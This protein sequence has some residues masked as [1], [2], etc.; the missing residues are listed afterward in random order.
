MCRILRATQTDGN[1]FAVI[2]A[3]LYSPYAYHVV[4]I[5]TVCQPPS[6]YI[7][8]HR[9]PASSSSSSLQRTKVLSSGATE[10][11]RTLSAQKRKMARAAKR[12]NGRSTRNGAIK[13]LASQGPVKKT[14]QQQLR[15]ITTASRGRAGLVCYSPPADLLRHSVKRHSE[16]S[17]I[18]FCCCCCVA[19]SNQHG[20]R[21]AL[22]TVDVVGGG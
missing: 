16:A 3:M 9:Q 7:S 4:D 21:I 5:V 8:H 10:S 2:T 1:V 6:P 19:P 22:T 20:T 12:L 17:I 11:I 14:R 13:S 15:Q 18:C